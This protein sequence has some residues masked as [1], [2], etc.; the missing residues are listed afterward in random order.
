VVRECPF[1]VMDPPRIGSRNRTQ[2]LI[3]DQE[4]IGTL[5]NED[6]RFAIEICITDPEERSLGVASRGGQRAEAVVEG[7]KGAV[8]VPDEDLLTTV[9]I[10]V[11]VCDLL[12]GR[13][14]R[15]ES[16]HPT[17]NGIEQFDS[18]RAPIHDALISPADDDF[19]SSVS[20]EVDD[21]DIASLR[22]GSHGPR[23]NEVH[24]RVEDLHE[25]VGVVEV[26]NFDT[27]ARC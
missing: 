27:I 9:S 25:V 3:E 20:I 17:G 22:L 12:D 10:E 4:L 8:P 18:E 13:G 2:L 16:Q 6:L 5:T 1:D 19:G 11:G 24:P 7:L 14:D 21:I 26:A 23:P 15:K